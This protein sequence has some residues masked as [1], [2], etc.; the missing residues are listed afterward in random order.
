MK[1]Y[2]AIIT[3]AGGIAGIRTPVVVIVASVTMPPKGTESR[4]PAARPKATGMRYCANCKKR[5][6]TPVSPMVFRIPILTKSEA[7]ALL[8]L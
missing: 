7:T 8:I 3:K 5:S 6:C 1:I 2:A 4:N